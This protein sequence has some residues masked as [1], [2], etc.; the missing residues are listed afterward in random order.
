MPWSILRLVPERGWETNTLERSKNIMKKI[1]LLAL[2]LVLA[3]G[4]LGVAYALWWDD[5]YVD[6]QVDTGNINAYWTC[7]AAWDTESEQAPAGVDKDFS[8]VSCSVTDAHGNTDDTFV[9]TL[10]NAY[11]CIDYYVVADVHNNGSLPIHVCDFTLDTVDFPGTVDLM[12]VTSEGS[13]GTPPATLPVLTTWSGFE[14]IHPGDTAYVAFKVHLT[15]A[16]LEDEPNDQTADDYT[17][18]GKLYYQQWNEPCL[19]SYPPPTP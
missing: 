1:A 3:L 14:Q 7:Y 13:G 2:A 19:T 12:K 10:T 18:T 9:I 8:S 6:G 4:T 17:F 11:P 15:N 16:A 5:L